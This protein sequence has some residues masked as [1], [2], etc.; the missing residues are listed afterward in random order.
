MGY[1]MEV[2]GCFSEFCEYSQNSRSLLMYMAPLFL[3]TKYH[4]IFNVYFWGRGA[5]AKVKEGQR[6]EFK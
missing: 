1:C 6:E 2:G 4:D 5:L 3:I